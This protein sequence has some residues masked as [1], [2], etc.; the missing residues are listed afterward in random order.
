MLDFAKL[1]IIIGHEIVKNNFSTVK[2]ISYFALMVKC[3]VSGYRIKILVSKWTNG[4]T[5]STNGVGQQ[6]N[7][8]WYCKY[9]SKKVNVFT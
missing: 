9:N 3:V 1:D 7:N 8:I 6:K 5:D 4:S 2:S